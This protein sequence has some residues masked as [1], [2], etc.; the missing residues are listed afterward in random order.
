MLGESCV[1]LLCSV[2]LSLHVSGRKVPVDWFGRGDYGDDLHTGR[3][4]QVLFIP[5]S[6]CVQSKVVRVHFGK[7]RN[8][9]ED[10]HAL[11]V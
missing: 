6:A 1:L 2:V 7:W 10:R 5:S 4:P 8:A 9:A 11:E 3:L